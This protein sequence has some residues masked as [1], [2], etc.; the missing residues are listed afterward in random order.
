MGITPPC[1]LYFEGA[2][3]RRDGNYAVFRVSRMQEARIRMSWVGQ[4]VGKWKRRKV[5]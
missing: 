2:G 4:E 1:R 3:D 5:R